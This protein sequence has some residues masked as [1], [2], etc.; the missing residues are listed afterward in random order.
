V[1]VT[2]VSV[3]TF[4]LAHNLHINIVSINIIAKAEYPMKPCTVIGMF[5]DSAIIKP[6]D[7]TS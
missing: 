6:V 4:A 5:L 7:E 3:A 2:P 1:K